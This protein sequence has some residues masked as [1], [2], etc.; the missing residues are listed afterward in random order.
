MDATHWFQQQETDGY[1]ISEVSEFC[2]Y[3][4]GYVIHVT[5]LPC[6]IFDIRR[7][8]LQLADPMSI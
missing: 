1:A 6:I 7:V 5:V 8:A 4:S 3:K 2:C